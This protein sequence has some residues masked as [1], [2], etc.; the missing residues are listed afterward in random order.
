M[1][2]CRK[3]SFCC[4]VSVS[5]P[6]YQQILSKQRELDQLDMCRGQIQQLFCFH[7]FPQQ[8][9][10]CKLMRGQKI[11]TQTT[12]L[13]RV[14]HSN[15]WRLTITHPVTAGRFFIFLAFKTSAE[16][17]FVPTFTIPI[18]LSH[19]FCFLAVALSTRVFFRNH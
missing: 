12:L 4:H 17:H 16:R 15:E 19:C 1:T 14:R 10:S 18:E 7:N 13:P 5:Q 11:P 9:H 8:Y 2:G 3:N 6:E